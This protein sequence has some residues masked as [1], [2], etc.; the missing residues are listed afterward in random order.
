MSTRKKPRSRPKLAISPL[1]AAVRQVREA[2]AE[3]QQRFAE[4][5]GTSIVSVNRWE[6][7]HQEPAGLVFLVRLRDL[8]LDRHLEEPAKLFADAVERITGPIRKQAHKLLF[9]YGLSRDE[10]I[11]LAIAKISAVMFPE[12]YRALMDATPRTRMF[13][14]RL[15]KAADVNLTTVVN[16]LERSERDPTK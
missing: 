1:G 16:E 7:G 10:E 3:S 6:L 12:E 14:E 5:L 11:L 8:A 2:Y 9:A 4:R 15:A 13:V